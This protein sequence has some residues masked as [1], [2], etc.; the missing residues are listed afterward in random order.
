[1]PR[2]WTPSLVTRFGVTPRVWWRFNFDFLIFLLPHYVILNWC[3]IF[4]QLI[5][6]RMLTILCKFTEN[7]LNKLTWS[8]RKTIIKQKRRRI[9]LNMA[10]ASTWNMYVSLNYVCIA[11]LTRPVRSVVA[12][13]LCGSLGL[14]TRAGQ[15][16]HSIATLRRFLGGVLARLPHTLKQRCK[17]CHSST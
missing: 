10:C 9:C 2:R 15:I 5:F 8:G 12:A 11:L 17:S 7:I 13:H 6:V 14:N 3:K 16:G 4:F 1:M